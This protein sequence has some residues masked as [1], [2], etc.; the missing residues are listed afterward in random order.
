MNGKIFHY[1]EIAGRKAAKKNDRTWLLGA[2][3]IRADG[4]IVTSINGSVAIPTRQAHAEYRLTKKLDAGSVVYV[5]RVR[6]DSGEFGMAKPCANCEKA[7]RDRK[8]RKV[9]YTIGPNEFGVL[10]L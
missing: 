6:K 7:L 4:T 5:A 1:L 9:Y 8:V 10:H 2:V 3:G